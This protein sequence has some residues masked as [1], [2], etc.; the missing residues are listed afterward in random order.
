MSSLTG[1]LV[2]AASP[3]FEIEIWN[4]RTS[5]GSAVLV[6]PKAPLFVLTSLVTST[7]GSTSTVVFVSQ[8]GSSDGGRQ[9]LPGPVTTTTFG[10]FVVPAGKSASRVTLKVSVSLPPF[11]ASDGIIQDSTS[12]AA[13]N[14]QLS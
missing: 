4:V 6:G 2:A 13:L 12:V 1:T 9:L 14:E 5:P 7:A 11:A 8:S 3:L 10:R